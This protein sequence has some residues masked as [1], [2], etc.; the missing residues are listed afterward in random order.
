MKKELPTISTSPSRTG[1]QISGFQGSRREREGG[2]GSE[3]RPPPPRSRGERAD[4]YKK[5][6]FSN[7]LPFCLR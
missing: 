5:N 1:G 6:I 7:P 4:G 2:Q 3:L